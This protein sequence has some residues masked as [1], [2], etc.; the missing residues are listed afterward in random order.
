VVIDVT[1][2]ANG[3]KSLS[4]KV[5]SRV[6]FGVGDLELLS[7]TEVLLIV[8]LVMSGLTFCILVFCFFFLPF[9]MEFVFVS[10][11]SII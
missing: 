7:S 10:K 3:Y 4:D 9:D 8:G 6:V 2:K 11:P 1:F 5:V